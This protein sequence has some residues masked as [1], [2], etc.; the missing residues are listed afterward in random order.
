MVSMEAEIFDMFIVL[1]GGEAARLEVGEFSATGTNFKSSW[2]G[3]VDIG[4]DLGAW[5]MELLR[6]CV[7]LVASEAN[8]V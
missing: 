8:R 4:D 7:V 1:V 2:D 3:A 5:T 6:D